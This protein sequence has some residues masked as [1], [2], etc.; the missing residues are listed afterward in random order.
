MKPIFR[1]TIGNIHGTTGYQILKE[2]IK[3]VLRI[4]EH[5]FDY[6]VLYNCEYND[7]IKNIEKQFPFVTFLQQK[8]SDCPI[9]LEYPS[10]LIFNN[11]MKNGSMWK[12]CPARI[13]LNAH[14]IIADNDL[15]LLNRSEIID[16]FLNTND[17]NLIVQEYYV[18][19]GN[20]LKHFKSQDQ[21]YNSG[22]IGL[23]PFYDFGTLINDFWSQYGELKEFNNG[24]EQGLLT[25]VLL[26]EDCIIGTTKNFIGLHCDGYYINRNFQVPFEFNMLEDIFQRSHVLH[27]LQ[28]NRMSPHIGWHYYKSRKIKFT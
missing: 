25:N 3:S 22:F 7:Y 5:D 10:Q 2:S 26:Q 13:R 28:A 14:E 12:V 15:I 27:F 16:E 8:W 20:Y 17:K 6:F 1:W 23:R 24:D 19:L 9:P 11:Q 18:Y 21:G 4:Y